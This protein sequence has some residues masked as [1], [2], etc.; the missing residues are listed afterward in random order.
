MCFLARQKTPGP[1][2][3]TPENSGRITADGDCGAAG[4]VHV[5]STGAYVE[6]TSGLI[7]ANG[8]AGAQN[9]ETSTASFS[10]TQFASSFETH[11]F[12]RVSPMNELRLNYQYLNVYNAFERNLYRFQWRHYF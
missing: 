12:W 10:T 2:A 6:T 3:P 7:A 11:L 5:A 4:A 8:T 1:L 9:V